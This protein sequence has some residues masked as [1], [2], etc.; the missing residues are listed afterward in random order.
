MPIFVDRYVVKGTR[1]RKWI[2]RRRLPCGGYVELARYRWR[3][4]ARRHAAY[5]W[6]GSLRTQLSCNRWK[7]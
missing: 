5:L 3:W 6:P 4:Q 2:V 1:P 7:K